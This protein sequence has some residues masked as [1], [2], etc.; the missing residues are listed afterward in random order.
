MA[1]FVGKAFAIHVRPMGVAVMVEECKEATKQRNKVL[2]RRKKVL[3]KECSW[4]GM[5]HLSERA[6][7]TGDSQTAL[8][9]GATNGVEWLI[10]LGERLPF[11]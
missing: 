7:V 8:I 5:P 10:L 9:G 6:Q 4:L 3:Q 1:C 11:I 2:S